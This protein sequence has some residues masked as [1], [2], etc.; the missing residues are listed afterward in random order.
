MVSMAFRSRAATD[1]AVLMGPQIQRAP[2]AI[3]P[4][5]EHLRLPV[6]GRPPGEVPRGAEPPRWWWLG[7]HGGA[8]VSTLVRL[9]P[10]GWDANRA[11]PDPRFGGPAGVLLVC[12][13]NESGLTAAMIAMRQWRSGYTPQHVNVWGVVVVADA[14]G[15]LP[16]RLAAMRDRIGGTVQR[17]FT[18]PW[19]EQWRTSAPT[20]ETAPKIVAHLGRELSSRPW[21]ES[22]KGK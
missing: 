7:C 13:S 14:P 19:V 11:W 18:V 3:E 17:V 8:G 15:R 21:L 4:P 1:S 16:K 5:P 20:L 2:G 22:P 10:G 12:R 6:H 9:I